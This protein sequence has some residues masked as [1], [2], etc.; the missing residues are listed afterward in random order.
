MTWLESILI[1]LFNTAVCLCLPRLLT[2][3][4]LKTIRHK[5]PEE[6]V[7]PKVAPLSLPES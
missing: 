4:E 6:D 5:P 1:L 7:T 2:L 3:K